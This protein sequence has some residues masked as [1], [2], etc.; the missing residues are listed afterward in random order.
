MMKSVLLALLLVAFTSSGC[1]RFPGDYQTA[2]SQPRSPT[3]IDGPWQGSWKSATGNSGRLRCLL[4]SE[5]RGDG[6]WC[7]ARFEAKFWGLFTAHYT[8]QLNG[9]RQ[10]EA[11]HLS[12]D[13]DLGGLEG[14]KYH[15]EATITP[16]RFDATY[17]SPVDHGEFHLA[18]P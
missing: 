5:Y 12:G 14:G 13:Q 7:A 17:R 16:T 6:I 15:Y 10:G 2:A 18:R 8:V 4:A 9:T 1:S 3:T 11:A